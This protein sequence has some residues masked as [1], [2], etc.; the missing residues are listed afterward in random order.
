MTQLAFSDTESSGLNLW[1]FSSS[2][3]LSSWGDSRVWLQGV[4]HLQCPILECPASWWFRWHPNCAASK[5][6]CGG[7]TAS[8]SKHTGICVFESTDILFCIVIPKM[9][10]LSAGAPQ[11]GL[12]IFVRAHCFP[13]THAYDKGEFILLST[14]S[15]SWNDNKQVKFSD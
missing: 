4:G 14:P 9:K 5:G 2:K 3:I 13:K 10:V 8:S 1:H 11:G 12:R 7:R 6:S 15:Q